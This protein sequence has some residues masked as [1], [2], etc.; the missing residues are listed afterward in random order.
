MKQRGVALILVLWVL[1]ILTLMASSFTLTMHRETASLSHTKEN[2][3]ALA[4]AKSGLAL[5]Q[6]M[7]LHEDETKRWRIDGSIYEIETDNSLTRIRILSETG[8]ID[9]NSAPQTLLHDVLQFSPLETQAQLELENAILDWRDEDEN[10]RPFG[11]EKPEYKAAKLGYAPRNKPFRSFEEL[12][13]LKGI[14]AEVLAWMQPIFTIYAAG[15]TQVEVD[16]ASRE[17]LNVLPEVDVNLLDA[18]FL[19]KQ[20]AILNHQPMPKIP[21]SE[22]AA[23]A[24]SQDVEAI[25]ET[26]TDPE[27]SVVTISV[28]TI[29]ENEATARIDAIVEKADGENNLPFQTL[30]WK[31]NSELPSLFSPTLEPFL[32]AH[33]FEPEQK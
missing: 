25:T 10:T 28:E 17:V 4:Q 8:K 13:M 32:I 2:A 15:Q 24:M 11:A 5:A 20:K 33:Y 9:L 31:S 7:L 26:E 29:L 22:N 30:V 12:Q 1:S 18:Y 6:A 21:R 23:Q 14:T 16:V 3:Q 19:A 27:I